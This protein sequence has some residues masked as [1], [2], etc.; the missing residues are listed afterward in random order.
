MAP[1]RWRRWQVRWSSPLG[2][3]VVITAAVVIVGIVWAL[4]SLAIIAG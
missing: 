3:A 2:V 4:L 1:L